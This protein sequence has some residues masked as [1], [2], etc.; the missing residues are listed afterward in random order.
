MIVAWLVF[1][2]LVVALSLG[3][4]LLCEALAGR[5]LPG[6]LLIPAGFAGLVVAGH[7]TA[8]F[9]P[10]AELTVPLVVAL[11]LAGFA[12]AA[13]RRRPLRPDPAL[14]LCAIVVGAVYAAPVIATGE[15][16]FAGY[17]RL[18]DTATWLALTD[19]IAEHGRSL[20]G[21]APSSYE[22]TL[23]FNLG[24]GYP[25]GSFVPLAVGGELTGTDIAW[26]IQPLMS[27]QA[28]MLAL[29]LAG[30]LAPVVGGRWPRALAAAIAA[31]PALLVGYAQWGGVKEVAGALL[32]A[33]AVALALELATPPG[34][35]RAL[36]AAIPL[37]LACGALLAVLS[38]AG[39]I[40]LFPPLALALAVAARAAGARE[41]LRRALAAAGL[42]ALLSIPAIASGAIV[43]PTSSPLT[44]DVAQG[45][46]F[47][48]LELAQLLGVWPA[49]DFRASPV[50]P[51]ATDLLLGA[52]IAA[53][54]VGLGVAWWRRAWGLAA[55]A[56][57]TLIAC[58]VILALGSPWVDAKA[59]ATAGAAA[60][61]AAVAG[62]AAMAASRGVRRA[63]GV[64]ALAAVAAGVVW[65][66]ALAYRDV[67]LA[68]YEQLAELERVGEVIA[69]DG[70]ALMTE[71]QPYGVRHFL[72]EADPEG[73]SELR[74]R[75]VPLTSGRGVP[76]GINADTDELSPHAVFVYR[77]LVLRRSPVQSRPP[78]PYELVWRGEHYEVW[79]RPAGS[80]DEPARLALGD[81][82]DPTGRLAC[83]DLVGLIARHPEARVIAAKRPATVSIPLD[84][85]AHPPGWDEAPRTVLPAGDGEVEGTT[86]V[87]RTASWSAWLGGSVRGRVELVVDGRLV[88][89]ARHVLNNF[90]FFV[91]LGETELERGDHSFELR[92]SGTDLH[93]GS[94]GR[95][96]PVGPLILSSSE[97]ADA[98]IVRLPA[99]RARELCGQRLDWVEAIE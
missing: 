90:G 69:G 4:G 9:D 10:T 24:D 19:R 71:Y 78:S 36:R 42:T 40:W 8:S 65:S 28:G 53:G 7:A 49:G 88:G 20:D 27:V 34:R 67:S 87:P 76:K 11:A 22:A 39:A 86:E 68:P 55:Y 81:S 56:T 25:I 77:T 98:R 37:A 18:D 66:N 13:A 45:N 99:R 21:L 43:P 61:V 96:T 83:G 6:A 73:V 92:F 15:P 46:L 58:G 35:L 44:S 97:P 17:I 48:P 89:S 62:A 38:A 32:V 72:R 63:L 1:P 47:E 26:L 52:V 12:T 91:P 75:L 93:P 85:A 54:L 50:A 23:A 60:L 79:Q 84:E 5:R 74:R 94:G 30:L 80:A 95:P 33:L 70:P 59:M 31:Q 2:A 51:L 41:A 3:V 29:V 82:L 14:V 16:T 64:V 57:G